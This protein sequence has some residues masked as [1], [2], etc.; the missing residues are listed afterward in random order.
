MAGLQ[1]R[2][3]MVTIEPGGVFG[4]L[5]DHKGRP[6]IV[7][8]LHGTITDH[9][10]EE[11]RDYG[12]GPGWPEDQGHHALA[13]EQGNVAGCGDLGRHRQA[14]LRRPADRSVQG[15]R[16][17][18]G[19]RRRHRTWS[20]DRCFDE[21]STAPDGRGHAPRNDTRSTAPQFQVRQRAARHGR[22]KDFLDEVIG[23]R[24]AQNPAFPEMVDAALRERR[25][26]VAL[27]LGTSIARALALRSGRPHHLRHRLPAYRDRLSKDD[28]TDD[29]NTRPHTASGSVSQAGCFLKWPDAP[30][31]QNVAVAGCG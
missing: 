1:L 24:T 2:M 18:I 16:T 27:E 25:S 7:Y 20:A 31:P 23:E 9:R 17:G 11:T 10:D 22:S 12:P 15:A 21:A 30:P 29:V 28:R 26:A 14:K 5:H 13:R 8:V 6:G 19:W 3:R 4:P